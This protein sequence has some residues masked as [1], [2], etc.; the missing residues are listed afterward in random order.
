MITIEIKDEKL[1]ADPEVIAWLAECER[2]LNEVIVE[3]AKE[4]LITANV[5]ESVRNEEIV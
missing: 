1:K 4:L 2:L 3:K 5:K